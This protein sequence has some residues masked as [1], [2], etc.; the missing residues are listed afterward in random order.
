MKSSLVLTALVG[1]AASAADVTPVKPMEVSRDGGL[2]NVVLVQTATGETLTLL[3]EHCFFSGEGG[4]KLGGEKSSTDEL[5]GN[6]AWDRIEGLKSPGQRITLPDAPATGFC[7]IF[8]TNETGQ[9]I[10]V[11]LCSWK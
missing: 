6:K 9:T 5:N 3:P 1:S 11:E 7:R 10:T 8:V 4:A 2:P